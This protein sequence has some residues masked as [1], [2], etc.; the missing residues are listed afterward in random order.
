M[1]SRPLVAYLLISLFVV[2]GPVVPV[3]AEASSQGCHQKVMA[4]L[5]APNKETLNAISGRNENA[6]W[7]VFTPPRADYCHKLE[8]AVIGGNIWAVEYL[9]AHIND[10]DGGRFEDSH[11]ALGCFSDRDHNTKKLFLLVRDGKLSD[12]DLRQAMTMLPL[13]TVDHFHAQQAL[14]EARKKRVMQQIHAKDLMGV[15]AGVLREISEEQ[16]DITSHTGISK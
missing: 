16:A 12:W 11:R 5:A 4:F 7:R 3:R 15:K 8:K 10:V 13:S 9:V 1:R 14:L 6:C 2:V